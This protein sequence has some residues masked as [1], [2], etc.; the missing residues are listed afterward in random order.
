MPST[1]WSGT[2]RKSIDARASVGTAFCARSPTWPTSMPRTFNAGRVTRIA[3]GSG[4][5][6]VHARCSSCFICASTS[7]MAAIAALSVSVSGL[8]SSA[9]PA[10]VIAAFSSRMEAR[11]RTRSA[12]GFG[13]QL[14]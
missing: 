5:P 14:P 11:S 8:T 7:G 3:R 1:R 6:S 10:I 13:A 9:Y 2:R 4:A 12:P